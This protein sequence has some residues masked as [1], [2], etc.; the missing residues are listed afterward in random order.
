[1]LLRQERH[2]ICHVQGSF[3][4][5]NIIWSLAA[6]SGARVK[7]VALVGPGIR[8]KHFKDISSFH[9]WFKGHLQ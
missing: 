8:E 3:E 7:M 1:M 2:R 5:P 9:N 4:S 6:N